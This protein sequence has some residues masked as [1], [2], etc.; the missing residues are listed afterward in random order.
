MKRVLVLGGKGMLGH[1]VVR[2]LSGLN[3]INLEYTVSGDK[4][5]PFFFNVENGTNHLHEIIKNHGNFDYFINCIGILSNNIDKRNS[6]S[7]RNA[8]LI[9]GLFPHDLTTFCN[10]FGIRIMNF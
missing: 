1:I 5:N 4:N 6:N 8:I 3:G 10:D 9:N 2:T 7:V